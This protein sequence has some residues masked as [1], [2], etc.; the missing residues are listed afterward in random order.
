MT[1]AEIMEGL[2]GLV[3]RIKPEFDG[4]HFIVVVGD[5][6]TGKIAVAGNIPA[7]IQVGMLAVGI[8]F[9]TDRIKKGEK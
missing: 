3:D 4:M 6:E 9:Q 8:G 5:P 7:T 2:S 1:D